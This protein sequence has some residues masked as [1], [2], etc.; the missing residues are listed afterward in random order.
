MDDLKPL[1]FNWRTRWFQRQS[2]INQRAMGRAPS[3]LVRELERGPLA[4]AVGM[5]GKLSA[6]NGGVHQSRRHR[7][8]GSMCRHP[9]TVLRETIS[10]AM[11]VGLPMPAGRWIRW[12]CDDH[13]LRFAPPRAAAPKPRR[14]RER[15]AMKPWERRSQVQ[16]VEETK[17]VVGRT[18]STTG[19]AASPF[20][21]LLAAQR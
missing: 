21:N 19:A 15:T 6:G 7:E 12:R 8:R 2:N 17:P 18:P 1:W 11:E 14:S 3:W 4:P 20:E 16:P 10:D 13:R 9:S 5:C